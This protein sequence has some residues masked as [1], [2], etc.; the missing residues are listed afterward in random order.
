VVQKYDLGGDVYRSMG[1]AVLGT[2]GRIVYAC[3]AR[4]DGKKDVVVIGLPAGMGAKP[5]AVY[6]FPTA[7]AG[8]PRAALWA[9]DNFAG[10]ATDRGVLWFD[11][12]DKKF[13]PMLV[14]QPGSAGQYF[15]DDK[16][17]WYVIPHPKEEGKSVLAALPMPL[18]AFEN[19]A[20]KFTANQPL[21]VAKIDAKG[22][23][24]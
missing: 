24:K 3:E 5:T 14:T 15:G 6:R 20:K 23:S 16:F 12:H 17:F 9:G 7:A 18:D 22:L 10:V 19:Y 21:T 1:I 4:A 2:P 13:L 8:E 11:D